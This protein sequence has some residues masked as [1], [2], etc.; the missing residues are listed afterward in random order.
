MNILTYMKSIYLWWCSNILEKPLSA[1]AVTSSSSTLAVVSTAINTSIQTLDIVI[2]CLGVIGGIIA[3]ATGVFGFLLT[4]Y[5][6]KHR[7]ELLQKD[8]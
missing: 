7:K 5:K 4:R 3:V 8:Q 2:R 6:W 1:F